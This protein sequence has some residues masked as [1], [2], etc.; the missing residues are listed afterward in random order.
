[1]AVGY[2]GKG[3]VDSPGTSLTSYTLTLDTA[4]GAGD[5]I[6][7]AVMET[8]SSPPTVTGVSGCGATWSRLGSLVF[9][10]GDLAGVSIEIWAG[11]NATAGNTQV[12]YTLSAADAGGAVAIALSGADSA[13]PPTMSS[14][15]VSSTV[16]TSHT[17]PSQTPAVG[18]AVVDFDFHASLR[19]TS[20]VSDTGDAMTTAHTDV[21]S[22]GWFGVFA[23]TAYRLATSTAAEA[24]TWNFSGTTSG[25]VA[26]ILVAAGSP[27]TPPARRQNPIRVV[28][29]IAVA[30]AGR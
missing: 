1:M 24:R 4:T 21:G 12:T 27:I 13:N 20:S 6:L 25:A 26:G 7:L 18:Q 3:N 29:G 5:C 9:T 11:I 17:A 10:G 22:S 30:R 23:S 8:T 2:R 19:T 28:S 14:S 15:V 16:V